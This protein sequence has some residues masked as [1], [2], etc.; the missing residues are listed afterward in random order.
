MLQLKSFERNK[1]ILFWFFVRKSEK[2]MS[3]D[4]GTYEQDR[5]EGE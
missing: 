4:G 3:G 2:L 5:R 1:V